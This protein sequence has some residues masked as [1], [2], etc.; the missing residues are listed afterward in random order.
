MGPPDLLNFTLIPFTHHQIMIS[1]LWQQCWGNHLEH[2]HLL[3]W[4]LGNAS[5]QLVAL[6][7]APN[8]DLDWSLHL[9][10]GASGQK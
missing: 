1:L 10:N 8:T 7:G 3:T 9:W 4:P 2:V 5:C 6:F